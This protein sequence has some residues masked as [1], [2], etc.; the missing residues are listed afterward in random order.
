MKI[1]IITSLFGLV[2]SKPLKYPVQFTFECDSEM[3]A[4]GWCSEWT[5]D[6][7]T[8][9]LSRYM[10]YHS[11]NKNYYRELGFDVNRPKITIASGKKIFNGDEIY[12]V[13]E[14]FKDT[15]KLVVY[16]KN[17]AVM[18]IDKTNFFDVMKVHGNGDTSNILPITLQFYD[19][20]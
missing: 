10:M 9:S 14:L 6:K 2:I 13:E 20:N 4:D 11:D 16:N 18:T 5:C 19:C 12:N 8:I 3:Y 17:E 15:S 7:W 1:M